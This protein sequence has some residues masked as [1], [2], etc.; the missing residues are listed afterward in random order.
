MNKLV[1]R[2]L[3]GV[4]GVPLF[5]LGIFYFFTPLE[6]FIDYTRPFAFLMFGYILLSF[7]FTGKSNLKW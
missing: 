2:V 5:A 4:I 6:E 3:G 1:F 7:S